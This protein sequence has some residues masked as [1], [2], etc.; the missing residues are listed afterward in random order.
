MFQFKSIRTKF[1]AGIIVIAIAMAALLLSFTFFVL[2]DSL[3]S[4]TLN[5]FSESTGRSA[6]YV[7]RWFAEKDAML[8]SASRIVSMFDTYESIYEM[9]KSQ[10][11]IE[12]DEIVYTGVGLSSGF[13]VFSDGWVPGPD[14]SAHDFDWFPGSLN[15]R[16]R[17]YIAS[18]GWDSPTSQITITLS[19]FS[20]MVMG[21]ESVYVVSRSIVALVDFMNNLYVPGD[22]YAFLVDANGNIVIHPDSVLNPSFNEGTREVEFVT[23]DSVRQYA[24]LLEG[25]HMTSLNT[26]NGNHYFVQHSLGNVGWTLFVGVPSRY[27]FA[28]VN[29]MVL[30]YSLIT[31]FT[32]IGMV[33][34]VWILANKNLGKPMKRLTAAAKQ[35][36]EGDLSIQLDVSSDD[37]LGQ[38]SRYFMEM[39]NT[40]RQAV[41]GIHEMTIN[42]RD[43]DI[44]YRVDE[45]SYQGAYKDVAYGVNEMANMFNEIMADLMD[46]LNRLGSGDFNATMRQ[47][48]GKQAVLND[49]IENM[50]NNLKKVA[51]E[52]RKVVD[53]VIYDGD[54]AASADDVSMSGEWKEILE[55]ANTLMHA[56]ENPINETMITLKAIS[57]GDFS[58]NMPDNFKGV[59]GEIAKTCNTTI[60]EIA[61]YIEEIQQI[62]AALANGDLRWTIDRPYVG[63]FQQI[64]DSVNAIAAKLSATM[65]GIS[66][67]ADEVSIGAHKLNESAAELSESVSTQ[68]T[69]F[70]ELSESIAN[71]DNRSK[72]NAENSQNAA[73]L[74]KTSRA[75]AETGNAEM[76]MLLEAMDRIA[77]SSDKISQII[78]T[79]EGISF[80]TNLLALNA[81]VEAARAG[82]HGRGFS[83]VAEE[84]RNLAGR[85]AEASKQTNDLIQE[86]LL[87][88]KE[89]TVR[90]NDTA[91]SLDKIAVNVVDVEGV[92]NEIYD[93]STWQSQAIHKINEILA[94]IITLVQGDANTSKETAGT[95][96]ELDTQVE[97]LKEKLRFFQAT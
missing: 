69:Q 25:E 73:E 91:T 62:L 66:I 12:P 3:T 33:T 56:V 78:K 21:M 64:K 41:E 31:L 42:Y 22:G 87:S 53:K 30:W 17:M 38:F 90:A 48:P 95:A 27:V 70:G 67:V 49:N 39:S 16:N 72:E 94:D 96:E 37:E 55:S 74:A 76:K 63:S 82:E 79:I 2:G 46:V 84:V 45:S 28:E 19:R 9:L 89:G 77:S 20:G 71:V 93:T 43:G 13:A 54:L 36:S 86:A 8:D 24:P 32:A 6:A 29:S 80:Q 35:L 47:L 23:L 14:W 61:S 40:M 59:F 57:E 44:D 92:V 11:A 15:N 81:S 85:S 34:V 65:A 4:K 5:E 51:T 83:V 88:I 75:N 60:F 10:H 1:V 18:P 7:E 68:I 52:I 97:I 26:P 58:K 50:R